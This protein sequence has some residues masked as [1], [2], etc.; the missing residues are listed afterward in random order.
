M[1]ST[2][3]FDPSKPV[4]TRDGRR[5]EILKTDLPAKDGG[6]RIVALVYGNNGFA[7]VYT[8]SQSGRF[9]GSIETGWDLM[10]VPEVSKKIVKICLNKDY[11]NYAAI[12]EKHYE[13]RYFG[14]LEVLYTVEETYEDDVLVS[15]RVLH[16]EEGKSDD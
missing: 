11:G 8:Y 4:Q 2:K 14:M 1:P 16:I 9:V 12:E 6:T 7:Y 10:N 15:A 5:V 3:P 13:P